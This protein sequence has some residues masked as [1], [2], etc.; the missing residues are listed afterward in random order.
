MP[1]YRPVPPTGAV[2]GKPRNQVAAVALILALLAWL[3]AAFGIWLIVASH[4]WT[5]GCRV[6][7][8]LHNVGTLVCLPLGA[9]LSLAAA[10]TGLVSRAKPRAGGAYRA[11]GVAAM[12]M[13]AL[14]VIILLFL[15][16]TE[17]RP[18]A[19]NPAYLHSC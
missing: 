1:P 9:L 19:I 5:N 6:D 16:S 11:M 17:I 4:A 12:V 3:S 8:P 18:H 13:G 10:I 14:G 15:F 2:V 7:E